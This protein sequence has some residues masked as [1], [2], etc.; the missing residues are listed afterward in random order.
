MG[1]MGDYQGAVFL[2]RAAISDT[3]LD[4]RA[5]QRN[6][7]MAFYLSQ[8]ESFSG[9]GDYRNAYSS[10]REALALS[11]DLYDVTIHVVKG[12][13]YLTMLA[14]KYNT[15]VQAILDVNGLTNTTKID[16]NLEL[17]IPSIEG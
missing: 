14:R 8:A 5:V 6:A 15:T 1:L 17:I 11:L 4:R 12:G 16:P 3:G 2:Y 7:D 13:D 10:Y 9:N